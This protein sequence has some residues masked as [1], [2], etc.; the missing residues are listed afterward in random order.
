[1]SRRNLV[2]VVESS[3][4]IKDICVKGYPTDSVLRH[5]VAAPNR[6]DYF[7]IRGG[8]V[9]FRNPLGRWVTCIPSWSMAGDR[10]LA[11]VLIS[12]A[13]MLL[14][15]LSRSNTYNY[16]AN[17]YWWPSMASEVDQFCSSCIDCQRATVRHVTIIHHG[18]FLR[19]L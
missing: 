11:E 14:G 7:C 13:H 4:D 5:I 16:L 15:H 19:T 9:Q 18:S 12:H 10:C 3:I 6:Q 17:V 2:E 1:V 8:L